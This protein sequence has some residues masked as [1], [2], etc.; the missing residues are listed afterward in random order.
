MFRSSM[1]KNFKK[2]AVKIML[3]ERTGKTKPEI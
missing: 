2:E 1:K 3:T